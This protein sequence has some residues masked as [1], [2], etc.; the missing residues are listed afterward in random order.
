MAGVS[1]ENLGS[2]YKSPEL[3]D[4]SYKIPKKPKIVPEH[5]EVENI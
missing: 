4:K 5:T 1:E 2:P 3:K